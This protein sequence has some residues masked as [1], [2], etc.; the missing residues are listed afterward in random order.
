LRT[1]LAAAVL[2]LATST[3]VGCGGASPV[4]TYSISGTIAGAASVT[5]NLTG[6]ATRAV[7]TGSGG[8]FAFTGLAA[9]NYTLTPSMPGSVFTPASRTV[10]L[11]V[12]SG[13]N[14]FTA[15]AI[16][17]ANITLTATL[18]DPLPV[19]LAGAIRAPL[20]AAT[21]WTGYTLSCV[22]FGTPPVAATGTADLAGFLSLTF[23]GKDVP[24]GCYLL[25]PTAR[26][27]ATLLFSSGARYG[28][29]LVLGA[30]VYL[31]TIQFSPDTGVALA[32][33]PAGGVLVTTTP[34]GVACPSGTWAMGGSSSPCPSGT[35]TA[36][37]WIAQNPTGLF[38]SSFTAYDSRT[39]TL[40]CGPESWANVPATV[41]GS[42]LVIGPFDASRPSCPA[43]TMTLQMTVDP[44][45]LTMAGVGVE[46]G[47]PT[48][49]T[50]C[51]CANVP[52]SAV[53]Q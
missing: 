1:L 18:S 11:S 8:T 50:D 9:G 45:C 53:R 38:L 32:Q 25:D 34:A 51:T 27:V 41:A 22:T 12:D 30:N 6:A 16:P 36:D 40:A 46:R 44:S 48:G 39:K 47:C 26:A 4:T 37:V 23:A 42:T 10:T 2:A 31:G 13:G 17:P 24:F 20:A 29:T 14:D 5:V 52:V 28:Q 7:V 35:V 19:I 15:S 33:V 49:Q 43:K 21:A 3:G